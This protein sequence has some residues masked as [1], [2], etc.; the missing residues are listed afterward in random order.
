MGEVGVFSPVLRPLDAGTSKPQIS[1]R[2]DLACNHPSTLDSDKPAIG[3]RQPHEHAHHLPRIMHGGDYNP[4]QW[5]ADIWDEDVRLM[6]EAHVNVA[7]LPVFGWDNPYPVT[8]P[9]SDA[10][11]SD[12]LT[13]RILSGEVALESHGILIPAPQKV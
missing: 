3:H 8:V 4:E 12:L 5:P 2:G 1:T 11:H 7:T 13:G 9:L 10:A 6:R